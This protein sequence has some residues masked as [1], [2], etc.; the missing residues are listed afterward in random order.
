MTASRLQVGRARTGWWVL[1]GLL[2]LVVALV[3]YSFVGTFVFGIFIYYATRPIYARI[4]RRVH[5]PSVAAAVSLL[6]IALPVILLLSYTVAIAI[7]ELSNLSQQTDLGR[8]EGLILPYLN[9]ADVPLNPEEIL[10][11]NNID[12]LSQLVSSAGRYLG[13]LGTAALHLFV[14]IAI[15][16]YLLR[17]DYRLS[18][19]V[20]RRFGDDAG[21]LE[22]YLSAVDRDYHQIFFGNILNAVI[23][24]TIGALIYSLL[25]VFS[26]VGIAIPY[27]TLL[28]LLAGVASLIP[29]VGM[30]LVYFPATAYLFGVAL[31]ADD[32]GLLWFPGAFFIL[33]FVVVD[34]IPD[35]VLRPYVSGRSLHVGMVMFAYILGPLLFGWYGIFLGPMLLVLVVHFT[36]IVLPELITG[37]PVQPVAVDPTYLTESASESEDPQPSPSGDPDPGH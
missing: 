27:P 14:M 34:S 29:V 24:G 11:G 6:L 18:R 4:R 15:A 32:P 9:L 33:S 25:D 31:F 17:D 12:A 26:P 16:F 30:K 28:G 36:R 35:L 1:G 13:L 7:Q 19:W 5:P 2:S 20:R 3:L 8:L 22:A 37:E 10:A 21:V 23:T